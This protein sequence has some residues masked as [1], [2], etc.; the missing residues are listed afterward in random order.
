[1]NGPFQY[2]FANG[3]TADVIEVEQRTE[4][5]TALKQLGFNQYYPTLV[6]VGGASKI[7]ESD[8]LRLEKI[9]IDII[10]PLVQELGIIVIDGGT[11]AGIMKLIGKARATIGGTFPLI[12]VAA[13][14]TVELSDVFSVSHGRAFL[15]PEHTHFILVPGHNWGDESPWLAEIP[16]LFSNNLPS[17]TLVI[18]GGEITWQDVW[19]SVNEGRSTMILA[20]SGRTADQLATAVRGEITDSRA[21]PLVESGLLSVIDLNQNS[22]LLTQEIKLRLVSVK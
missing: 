15:A 1:M 5:K 10:T 6:L 13:I 18:N 16:T 14:G 12:G 17:V 2:T 7:T 21:I 19:Y 4:L 22:D 20:G 11:D 8:L 9:F 3:K